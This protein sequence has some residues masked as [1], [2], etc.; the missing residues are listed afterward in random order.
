M[1]RPAAGALAGLL[2]ASFPFGCDRGRAPDPSAGTSIEFREAADAERLV[3]GWSGFERNGEG[4]TFAWAVGTA[5][6]LRLGPA[7]RTPHAIE[8]RAW[9]FGFPGAAPQDVVV[10]VNGCRVGE[11]RLSPEPSDYV[12]DTPWS[13]WTDGANVLSFAFSRADAPRDR[14]PGAT[15][16]RPLSAGFDRVRVR[17]EPVRD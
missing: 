17:P 4:V 9:A 14:I 1:K 10:F 3:S 5:A 6:A 8:L 11:L 16:E 12:L 2:A 7:P 15:D 13:V